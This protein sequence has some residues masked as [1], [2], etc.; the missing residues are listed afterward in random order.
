MFVCLCAAANPGPL[1]VQVCA[2]HLNGSCCGLWT[3]D[4]QVMYC[5]AT[6]GTEDFYVYKL[7]RSVHCDS[8]YCAVNRSDVQ[9]PTKPLTTGKWSMFISP[10]LDEVLWRQRDVTVATVHWPS[11]SVCSKD[12]HRDSQLSECSVWRL[13]MTGT[14]CRI[15]ATPTRNK[16]ITHFLQ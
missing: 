4:I 15:F 14:H 8:A 3:G 6:N 10:Y 13:L 16:F 7:I 5:P 12:T 1:T 2:T 11:T 9:S